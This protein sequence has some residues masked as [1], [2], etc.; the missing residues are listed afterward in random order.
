MRQALL[1]GKRAW[2]GSIKTGSSVFHAA[3]L[4]CGNIV[5]ALRKVCKSG[6]Y[7]QATVA[8][9]PCKEDAPAMCL[10]LRRVGSNICS[11]RVAEP[12]LG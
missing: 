3:C 2:S 9:L 5:I 6:F 11:Y 4:L 12:D 1:S 8:Y 7:M 10:L